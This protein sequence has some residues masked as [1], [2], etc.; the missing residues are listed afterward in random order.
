MEIFAK[1][2]YG[3]MAMNDLALCYGEGSMVYGEDDIST[4]DSGEDSP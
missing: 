2:C 4:E 1:G 3:I